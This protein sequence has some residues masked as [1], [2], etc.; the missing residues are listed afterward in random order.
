MLR[1]AVDPPP[2]GS[3]TLRGDGGRATSEHH[4]L[5]VQSHPSLGVLLK[6]GVVGGW[7]RPLPRPPSPRGRTVRLEPI[8]AGAGGWWAETGREEADAVRSLKVR[9]RK[10]G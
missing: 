3:Y 2:S 7:S 4:P 5:S 6:I 1:P 10:R 8:A 9:S